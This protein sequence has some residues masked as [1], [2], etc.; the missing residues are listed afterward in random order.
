MRQITLTA[1]LGW[2][3]FVASV[4]NPPAIAQTV[5]QTNCPT[6]ASDLNID[7]LA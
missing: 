2:M 4:T 7:S 3:A 1:T 6:D 5:A